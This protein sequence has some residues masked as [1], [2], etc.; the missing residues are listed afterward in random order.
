MYIL[1]DIYIFGGYIYINIYILLF[2]PQ[3]G[4]YYCIYKYVV[5]CYGIDVEEFM[6]LLICNKKKIFPWELYNIPLL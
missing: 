2:V 5:V 3:G 4:K 6:Y 1:W